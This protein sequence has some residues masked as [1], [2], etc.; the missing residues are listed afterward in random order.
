MKFVYDPI[1]NQSNKTKH[2]V[3][4]QEANKLEWDNGLFWV[5][6]R[7]DYGEERWVGLVP[8]KN[9]LY[10]VVY[11]DYLMTRRIISLRKANLREFS[12]YEE[13]VN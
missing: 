5:D 12:F 7:R 11:V 6:N 3:S 10:C 4:L 8:M 13:K 1:K 9:R 2:G